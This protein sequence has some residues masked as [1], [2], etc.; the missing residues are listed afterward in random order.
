M[1]FTKKCNKCH[2]EK[3]E[4]LFGIKN[5]LPSGLAYTC[6]ECNSML[7]RARGHKRTRCRVVSPEVK[8]KYNRKY[9]LK[10][11]G[12]LKKKKA[13]ATKP[14]TPDGEARPRK[15]ELDKEWKAR[16]PCRVKQYAAKHR[17]NPRNRVSKSISD[18]IRRCLNGGKGG[19]AW[20]SLVGYT[21]KDLMAHLES[22]FTKGMSFENYGEWHI[23]HIRPISS[24]S[25][26]THKCTDFHECWSLSNLQ[27]LWAFDNISK[28]STF[29]NKN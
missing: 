2:I 13:H 28:G 3:P 1:I 19:M 17:S 10:T 20:E 5:E 4:S 22:F 29:P 15:G 6:R 24:F 14:Q 8:A 11:R 21:N 9:Y 12:K 7:E 27:P 23:D 25:F 16:N 26:T 18:G